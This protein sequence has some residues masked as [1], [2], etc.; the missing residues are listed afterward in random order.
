MCRGSLVLMSILALSL[1]SCGAWRE[2]NTPKESSR[3]ERG[4]KRVETTPEE[5]G[6][7]EE[8]RR[9]ALLIANSEYKS[10]TALRTPKRDVEVMSAQLEALG[11]EVEMLSDLGGIKMRRAVK[12]SR[13]MQ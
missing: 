2:Q 6:A 7:E 1:T 12:A 8:G 11:Y 3:V 4:A 9:R 10:E 5:A 13:S